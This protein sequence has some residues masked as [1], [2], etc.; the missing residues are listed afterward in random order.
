MGTAVISLP[1]PPIVVK[2]RDF[3]VGGVIALAANIVSLPANFRTGRRLRL[4]VYQVVSF[5]LA[6]AGV[7]F[8][9]AAM[10]T[11]VISLPLPPIVVKRRDFLVGGVI[12]PLTGIIIFPA[13]LCTGRCLCPMALQVVTLRLAMAGIPFAYTAVS[14]AVI[15]LPLLPIVVK[16]RVHCVG[17]IAAFTAGVV[18]FIAV[19][20]TG[21][22]LSLMVHQVMGVIAVLTVAHAAHS[23]FRA[24][25]RTAAVHPAAAHGHDLRFAFGA[26]P[27]RIMNV[28]LNPISDKLKSTVVA[29]R[30]AWQFLCFRRC[31][32]ADD[33]QQGD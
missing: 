19:L 17:G 10:G 20:C 3:L 7:P 14:T 9:Y 18:G 21:R 1:L 29:A 32:Q 28:S 4:K 27:Q 26:P 2:C 25:R 30:D 22:C 23:L 12:A 11:A 13:N 6:M 15:G 8:A 31:G 33:R 24:G 16:C 5:R